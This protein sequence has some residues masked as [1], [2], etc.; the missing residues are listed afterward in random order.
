M[1]FLFIKQFPCITFFLCT[2]SNVLILLR[3]NLVLY[4]QKLYA[5]KFSAIQTLKNGIIVLQTRLT[6][7]KCAFSI[8]EILILNLL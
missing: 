8:M 7:V 6:K 4:L 2:L 1:N 3:I 5:V